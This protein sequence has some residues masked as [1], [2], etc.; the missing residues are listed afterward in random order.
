MPKETKEKNISKR[1]TE[2]LSP[3]EKFTSAYGRVTCEEWILAEKRRFAK[4]GRL[5]KVEKRFSDEN[6]FQI[7]L[8]RV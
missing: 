5:T 7:A 4:A 8:V 6:V 2:W 1:I 3:K